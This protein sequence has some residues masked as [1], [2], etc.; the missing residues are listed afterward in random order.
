MSRNRLN[1]P[2]L[3]QVTGPLA[4]FGGPRD[5]W[6]RPDGN[7]G[8][9]VGPDA[10]S[11]RQHANS[12]YRL[13]SK[14]LRRGDIERAVNWLSQARAERHPGAA[15]RLVLALWQRGVA[16]GTQ[17]GAGP[18][19]VDA[20]TDAA[21]FGH[22]DAFR[23][24]REA[25]W[26]ETELTAPAGDAEGW[27][28]PEFGPAVAEALDAVRPSLPRP[29]PKP[30]EQPLPAAV[31][32]TYAAGRGKFS[33]RVLRPAALTALA[34]QTPA[35]SAE[36]QWESALRVLDVLDVIGSS[37]GPVSTRQILKATSLPH[38]VLEMLLLWLCQQ[39]LVRQLPDGGFTP[40]P[41]LIELRLPAGQGR[42]ERIL[43]TTL[44]R[45][46]DAAGAAVYLGTY[47]SGEVSITQCADGPT[48]PKVQE[49]VDFRSAAHASAVGKSLLQQLDFDRRMDHLSRHHAVRLTSRTIT[50]PARLFRNIDHH[51]PRALQFDL[52]E[53]STRE[54]CVAVS[55]G[56]GGQAG[57]VALSLPASQRHRLLDAARVLSDGSTGLL[58]SLLLAAQP[59][60]LTGGTPS[61]R[62]DDST[63][64]AGSWEDSAAARPP[65][66]P[67]G[68]WLPASDLR[69]HGPC[70][71]VRSMEPAHDQKL[72]SVTPFLMPTQHALRDTA[73]SQPPPLE[74]SALRT[75]H[76]VSSGR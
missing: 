5:H 38:R 32:S 26:P 15:L 35:P 46:R 28:D 51:G 54:V 29:T 12:C 67:N 39:R 37:L 24:L 13:G 7:W 76:L 31:A 34:Q 3:H 65:V 33:A 23:I 52:L 8:V 4:G 42:P 16:T 70:L 25:G 57:C 14:A 1:D 66:G 74:A 71:Q 22:G 47:T 19:A 62:T 11:R 59:P 40:G 49:W 61:I 73:I 18:Q 36:A 48:T 30:D 56:I 17:A 27:E 75:R 72:E 60:G 6:D 9:L 45:L 58:L 64:R 63:P 43:Q 21:R 53:Y 20:L 10:V 41:V 44:A 69:L 2:Y 50:D 68:L 55:L